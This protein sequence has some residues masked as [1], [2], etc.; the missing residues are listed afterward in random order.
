MALLRISG[1]LRFL[2]HLNLASETLGL[3]SRN[4]DLVAL[5]VGVLDLT[6]D[7]RDVIG[8]TR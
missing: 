4:L 3:S 6:F 7:L 2:S 1:E 8:T 5:L